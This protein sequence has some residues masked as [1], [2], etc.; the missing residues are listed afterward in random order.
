MACQNPAVLSQHGCRSYTMCAVVAPLAMAD[1]QLKTACGSQQARLVPGLEH[2][3][4]L[5]LTD[6]SVQR[7]QRSEV[8]RTRP[9][10]AN[11]AVTQSIGMAKE[12]PVAVMALQK[13]TPTTR[14]C[15]STKGPPELP[16][17]MATSVWMYLQALLSSPNSD[18]C[19]AQTQLVMAVR[20]LS[21]RWQ[22]PCPAA[23]Y[24]KHCLAS[25]P[26]SRAITDLPD[27]T[28]LSDDEETTGASLICSQ[29]SISAHA[30]AAGPG[31]MAHLAAGAGD[32]AC[33]DSVVQGERRPQCQHPLSHPQTLC[34]AQL[35]HW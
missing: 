34:S 13:E 4:A 20:A 15:R 12:T 26:S 21:A 10:S 32:D 18:A 25:L 8:G 2:I 24:S 17:L 1:V 30:H 6:L 3:L 16:V 29:D 28:Q 14:P 27:P 35:S 31:F 19:I 22:L 23:G 9:T 5:M 11:S 7:Q 33:R